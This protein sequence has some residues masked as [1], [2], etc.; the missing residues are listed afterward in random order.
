MSRVRS[1]VSDVT[2]FA[3]QRISSPSCYSQSFAVRNGCIGGLALVRTSLPE[4]GN[5]AVGKSIR[6]IRWR[7]RS[8]SRYGNQQQEASLEGRQDDECSISVKDE[9]CTTFFSSL[10]RIYDL[11]VKLDAFQIKVAL[12]I[13]TDLR[14]VEP[15]TL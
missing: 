9:A 10:K 4:E 12:K 3:L 7:Q 2:F 13:K 1:S 5:G 11:H 15:D 8:Q 14:R 6:D